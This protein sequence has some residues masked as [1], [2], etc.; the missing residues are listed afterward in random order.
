MKIA[1]SM[2][3]AVPFVLFSFIEPTQRV[4]FVLIDGHPQQQWE[5]EE[6]PESLSERTIP[7]P[8]I[9]NLQRLDYL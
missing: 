6:Q 8:G 9:N 5:K 3:G 2:P 1:S 7:E 4:P